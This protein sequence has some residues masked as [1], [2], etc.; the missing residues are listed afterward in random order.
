MEIN[1]QQR[2]IGLN[3]CNDGQATIWVWAPR[4]SGVSLHITANALT[5][6]LNKQEMGYW[7]L[8]TEEIRDGDDYQ[9][10]LTDAKAEEKSAERL[11]KVYPDPASLYQPNGVHGPSRAIDLNAFASD[12]SLWKGIVLEDYIIYELHTGTFTEKGDFNGI[13]EK[14]DHLV[15]LGIT[16]IEIMP[17]AQFPGNRN[18]GYDGVCAF[19]VQNSYGGPHALKALVDSCH[20]KGLAVI[21]DVVFNHFGPE[22]NYAESFGPYA[23]DKYKTPWGEAMNFDDA[24]SDGVRNFFIENA[25]MW[26]RDFRIDALRL[27][28]VHAIKDFGSKHILSELRQWVSQLSDYTGQTYYLLAELDLNDNRYLNPADKG[29]YELDAQWSD[30][31]HHALRVSAGQAPLGYYADFNGI[32]DLAKAFNDAY[33]YT[34]AYSEHRKKKFGAPADNPGKQFIVFSQNHDQIGNRMLGERSSQLIS[35]ELSKVLAGAVCCSPFL[36]LLFMGEEWASVSPFQYF[37]SHTDAKLTDSVRKGR[38]NEFA[39]FHAIDNVPDP[40]A[41]ETFERS[42]LDWENVSQAKHQKMLNYYKAIISLRKSSP[43]LQSG[44]QNTRAI[45]YSEHNLL[46]LHRE[47]ESQQVICIFNFSDK[48]ADLIPAGD[49]SDYRL[50]LNSASTSYG[51]P[52]TISGTPE[53]P[54]FIQSESLLIFIK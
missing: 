17:V 15:D 20:E 27:D 3:F 22:G 1:I 2:T 52:D 23:T 50:A 44:R 51:G 19:A 43:A 49:L 34:G 16:A 42:K 6:P 8:R 54:G 41:S 10:L 39:A 46:V 47:T 7:F 25:L 11:T 9:I 30:E 48:V 53:I 13:E 38:Q 37:I 18:W 35:Y 45:A 32:A 4:A 29:G 31:F 12:S 21:L 33:V 24:W 36:P 5:L 26:L 14:L 28:A 40:A